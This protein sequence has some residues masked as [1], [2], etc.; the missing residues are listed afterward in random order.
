MWWI[1]STE[2]LPE[3][4]K[5]KHRFRYEISFL[6]FCF[7]VKKK[8][9]HEPLTRLIKDSYNQKAKFCFYSRNSLFCF[10]RQVYSGIGNLELE[11][12][13]LFRTS[14]DSPTRGFL[15]C[16]SLNPAQQLKAEAATSLNH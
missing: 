9:K 12:N 2:L 15:A 3:Q 7:F 14:A 6:F 16:S 11:K 13:F 8:K 4:Q 5:K 10:L 1:L